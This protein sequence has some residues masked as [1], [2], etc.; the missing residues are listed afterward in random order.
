MVP[1]IHHPD[2]RA[3]CFGP[4]HPFSPL[5]QQLLWSLLDALGQAPE[6]IEPAP[7]TRADLETVHHPDLIDR[8]EAASS[9]TPPPDAERFGLGTPD[10]P[11]FAGMDAAARL[12]V[13]GTVHAVQHV[14]DGHARQVLQLGGGLHHARHRLA[15][16]FCV[17]NDLS[18]A[19]RRATS[20]GRRVAYIDIDVHH[21]DGV[22]WIHYEE[23]TVL[24]ISLHEAGQYLFPGTGHV[25]E[26]GRDFG[27][28]FS[29]NVPLQPGTQDD[30]YREAF[31]RVVPQALDWFRPDLLV[32]Q[33]GADAH[34][35]DPL[36]DLLLTTHTYAWLFRALRALADEYAG[37]RAV[38]T[39][40]GGYDPDATVR[41]WALLYLILQDLEL[42]EALPAAWLA[43][44]QSHPALQGVTL[45]ERLHDAPR[46][47][48]VHD[49][50]AIARQNREVCRRLMEMAVRYWY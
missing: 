23:D 3:Y 19:I 29:F 46:R 1:V 16:G 42:P 15:A 26:L 48:A 49:A 14:L 25:H 28:G 36:A 17:Y 24:T 37:G 9:G 2:Y 21:G 6:A 40:G 11:V 10:V 20:A 34:W 4:D 32:V 22:Q 39:L 43:E 45:R 35:Q 41:V 47:F 8:V 27:T 31:E 44:W 33:C 38:F 50:E 5:R 30:S 12:L 18:V 13:G 7:A